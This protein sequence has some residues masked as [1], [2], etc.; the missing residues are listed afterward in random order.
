MKKY[1]GYFKIWFIITGIFLA[2]G[3]G[4]KIYATSQQVDFVRTNTEALTE[5]RVFDYADKMTDTQEELLREQIAETE[6][7]I[8]CDIIIVTLNETLEEYAKS[9]E[10]QIGPV[11]PYQYTMVYA[12]NFYDENKFG[13]NEPYGDGVLLLDNWYREKDGKIHSWMCTTGKAMERYSSEMIDS[14]LSMALEDVE[15][16]PYQAYSMF[17]SLVATDMAQKG[18]QAPIIPMIFAFPAALV[19]AII[20]YFA[21]YGGKKGDKTVSKDTYVADGNAKVLERR[22]T[23]INKTITKR[24]IE[25][26]SSSGGGGGGAH[27]SASGRSH[28]GGGHS[29]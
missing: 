13:Y 16:D 28:G 18:Q 19:I 9:Y 4:C 6:D 27:T 10:A 29:R 15:D 11:E 8:G 5:E 22:D 2:A 21:N 3:I 17:V 25:T 12:D 7:K 14:T 23:F 1:I 24:V 20:F 26:S